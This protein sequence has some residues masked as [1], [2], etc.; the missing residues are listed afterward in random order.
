MLNLPLFTSTPIIITSI[1]G[2]VLPFKS[3]VL[4]NPP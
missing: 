4:L 1:K 3:V 2:I